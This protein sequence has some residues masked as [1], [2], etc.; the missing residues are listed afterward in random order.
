MID[1]GRSQTAAQSIA[2]YVRLTTLVGLIAGIALSPRLWLADRLFPLTPLVELVPCLRVPVDAVLLALLLIGASVAVLT[3]TAATMF[4]VAGIL[5]CL[6]L[7]DQTRLQPWV[8]MYGTLL[9]LIGY[10]AT[11][12]GSGARLGS[13][14][15]GCRAVV[16]GIYLWSG[17][18]KLNVTFVFVVFPWFIEPLFGTH[19]G[20]PAWH[21]M[22]LFA[23]MFEAA[24]G[25]LLL[26]RRTRLSALAMALTVHVVALACLGPWGHDTNEVIWPW[27]IAMFAIAAALFLPRTRTGFGQVLR[28]RSIPHAAAVLLFMVLPGLSFAGLW[29]ALPSMRLYSGNK[30]M[31]YAVFTQQALQRLPQGLQR[32]VGENRTLD[33]RDWAYGELNAPDYAAERVFLRIGR[34]LC[35][36]TSGGVTLV[37]RG[38][39]HWRTGASELKRIDACAIRAE[40][41]GMLHD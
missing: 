38:I 32:R 40:P 3:R 14:L 5:I 25:A 17:L 30:E 6:F 33:F 15:D 2:T 1:L 34:A 16:A 26:F 12:T 28:P 21:W 31:A 37:I 11:D 23:G 10:G 27:N 22:A 13:A 35:E 19:P 36:T 41:R 39:P 7:L 8:Y 18:Q 4:A 29:D 9:L 20:T 24:I